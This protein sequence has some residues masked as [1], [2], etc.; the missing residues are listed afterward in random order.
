MISLF[1][2]NQI[3]VIFQ[4]SIQH[5]LS[6]YLFISKVTLLKTN[7]SNILAGIRWQVILTSLRI[8]F[9]NR[10][11]DFYAIIQVNLIYEFRF[12]FLTIFLRLIFTKAFV[13]IQTSSS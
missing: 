6:R 2:H 12:I 3:R 7:I 10:I 9:K 13:M 5:Q 11:V 4:V 1:I 8:F